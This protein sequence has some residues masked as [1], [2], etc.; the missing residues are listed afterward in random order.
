MVKYGQMKTKQHLENMMKLAS[1]E[2][3]V[4]EI[5]SLIKKTCP[6]CGSELEGHLE[7][8]GNGQSEYVSYCLICGATIT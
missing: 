2:H 5:I 6:E 8:R 1:G 7:Y 4:E 3:S